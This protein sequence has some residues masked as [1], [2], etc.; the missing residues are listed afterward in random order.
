MHPVSDGKI[1]VYAIIVGAGKG[2]RMKTDVPK[3]YLS[4]NN[5][6]IIAY[7]LK[8]F[9][10][11]AKIDSIYW[12][13][14]EKDRNTCKEKILPQ[15]SIEKPVHV[16][17]GGRRR[18]DSVYNGLAAVKNHT[19]IVAIHDG[20]RPFIRPGQISE[21]ITL[22]QSSG[23]CILGLP[24]SDTLKSVNASNVIEGTVKRENLWRAQTPQT[25]K[26]SIIREAH[27]K[28]AAD[29]YRGTDDASLVE[30]YGGKVSIIEGS[31]RNIKITKPED[32]LIAEALLEAE[33]EGRRWGK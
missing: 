11:C 12:A 5:L 27:E 9:A 30:H 22:A 2:L 33:G 7:S 29:G 18:Q 13:V 19:S 8:A 31:S 32:L 20:V 3:Q 23:A 14:S 4:L 21:S 1:P 15:L 16:L 24:V 25:F 6:P 26:Y 28:A 17:Q 10:D